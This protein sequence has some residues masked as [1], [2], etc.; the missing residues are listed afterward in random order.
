MSETSHCSGSS[1]KSTL[2]DGNTGFACIQTRKIYAANEKH[3][4]NNGKLTKGK[5]VEGTIWVETDW[6][7]VVIIGEDSTAGAVWLLQ[8]FEPGDENT[9]C[10][11]FIKESDTSTW[12]YFEYEMEMR[13]PP[14]QRA[15]VKIAHKVTDLSETT[16]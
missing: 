6:V 15:A 12:G 2:V 9:G 11:Y 14:R 4:S 10:T 16:Q 3:F 5:K 7:M 8:N 1:D 13:P